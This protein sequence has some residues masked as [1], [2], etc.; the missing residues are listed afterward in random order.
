MRILYSFLLIPFIISN[1]FAQLYISN[2]SYVY[3]KG[4]VVYS[5]GNLELNGSNSVFYLRNEGQFLQGTTGTSTNK[6]TGKLSVYQEG[7]VNNYAYNYWC[8]PIGNA[9]TSSGNE[10]FGITM[11]NVP[12][13]N[14]TSS[15][16]TMIAS[17]YD[18]TSSNG[19]LGIAT[20]WIWKFLSSVAYSQWIQ[21][22]AITNISAGQGFTM[23]GTS[24][25][26]ATNVGETVVN[27]PG[28]AQRYDFRGKPN[29]GTI[30]VNVGLNNYTLTG[31]PYPSALHVNA[32]LLDAANT[33]CTGI[34]YYWE[35][36]KTVNSHLLLAYRGGY[37]T[38]SPVA[39]AST[40]IYVPATFDAYTITGTLSSTGTSSGLSISRKYAPIGQGFMVQGASNGSVYLNNTHRAFYKESTLATSHFEK[41]NST[42][43]A[44]NSDIISHI[45][46]NTTF[47]NLYTRQVALAFLPQATDDIDRG[48]DAVSP[49][50]DDLPSDSYFILQNDKY[51]IQGIN[52][53]I[54]KRLPFGVTTN[55][56]TTVKFNLADEIAFDPAQA[57]YV[58]DDL[59]GS[60]HNLKE[61]D[62]EVTLLA[63]VYNN[64][65][66]ITFMDNK[67]GATYNIKDEL[68]VVQNNTLEQ[69]MIAN[70]DLLDIQSL[71]LF[72]ISGKL[73]YDRPNI[74]AKDHYEL[75]TAT[76]SDGVYLVKIKSRD[77]Q[78]LTQKIIVS[79]KEN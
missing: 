53:N 18:G 15:A 12:T 42:T 60:Y 43:T 70:N 63:G 31:N 72:D 26:D 5:K 22:A 47:N 16:A 58:Y 69:L 4:G 37:G 44:N 7:T 57:I 32:F 71:Q 73:I 39:L 24:G 28:S 64:R 38:Y 61:N 54:S 25:T 11:L 49:A 77:A 74:G 10:D 1:A 3:N 17:G 14:T 76:L 41:N 20:Y 78:T 40:G 35:Q 9:S 55:A 30:T 36:D 23:K 34:A 21:S 75:S 62:F 56:T 27:N 68:Q 29:D 48:I 66:Q 19:S 2:N 52:F 6:G 46:L 50:A 51:V 33:A 13:S 45:R 65:F 79:S 8:S 67:L 59:D